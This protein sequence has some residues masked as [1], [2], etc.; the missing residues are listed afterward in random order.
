MPCKQCL[1]HVS[2]YGYICAISLQCMTLCCSQAFTKFTMNLPARTPWLE[3][4]PQS[5]LLGTPIAWWSPCLRHGRLATPCCLTEANLCPAWTP[6]TW[7]WRGHPLSWIARSAPAVWWGFPQ[8]TSW[9]SQNQKSHTYVPASHVILTSSTS[10][11]FLVSCQ[12]HKHTV[13]SQ[14]W[15][16]N[17]TML[18]FGTMPKCP[19]ICHMPCSTLN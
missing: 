17:D 18:L 13:W 5:V 10:P 8:C 12:I 11:W 15:G 9:W 16:N 19:L 6:S 14:C 2:Q 4:K 1:N 3:C 7:G